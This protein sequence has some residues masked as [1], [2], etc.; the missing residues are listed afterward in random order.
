M[1]DLAWLANQDARRAEAALLHGTKKWVARGGEG[2]NM[3]RRRWVE[4]RSA[5]RLAARK[6]D[7]VVG[8]VRLW[9]KGPPPR[10]GPVQSDCSRPGP[11]QSGI[12]AASTP[13]LEFIGDAWEF[14]DKQVNKMRERS[15]FH[16]L[17]A[18]SRQIWRS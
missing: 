10:P 11:V 8:R 13:L 4:R 18:R 6:R 1:V 9:G 15:E 16:E 2:R 17:V 3:A 12:E 5:A 14:E 7:C